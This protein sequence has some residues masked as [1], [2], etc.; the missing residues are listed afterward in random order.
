MKSGNMFIELDK[1]PINR[2]EAVDDSGIER[3]PLD[4]D[5][6]ERKVDLIRKLDF[7]SE[8]EKYTKRSRNGSDEIA[9]EKNK[10]P[11]GSTSWPW[12]S[13]IE[14]MQAAHQELSVIIDIINTV[15]ANDAVTVAGMTKPKPLTNEILSDL[16]V[17]TATKLQSIRHL[18]KYFKQGSK[19]FEKLVAKETRFYNALIRLQQNWKVK[20]HRLTISGHSNEGFTIDLMD[21]SSSESNTFPRPFST[22]I[23]RVDRDLNGKLVVQLPLR[24]FRS[25]YFRFFDSNSSRRLL[26]SLRS[27]MHSITNKFPLDGNNETVVE[28]VNECVKGSHSVL[29]NIHLSLFEEKVFDFVIH[30]ALASLSGVEIVTLYE[31]FLKLGVGKGASVNLSLML[32]DEADPKPIFDDPCEENIDSHT[33]LLEELDIDREHNTFKETITRFPNAACFQIHLTS[34]VHEYMSSRAKEGCRD[35]IGLI[36]DFCMT[37]AHSIFSQKVLSDLETLASG[38]PYL[39]LLTHPTWH[40][41]ISSWSL[42][43]KLPQSILNPLNAHKMRSEFNIKVTVTDDCVKVTGIGS[44]NVIDSFSG[45]S[46]F[47]KSVYSY[48]DRNLVD[49]KMSLL[50]KIACQLIQWLHEEALVLGLIASRDFLTLNFDIAEGSNMK[51]MA[52][53]DVKDGHC[54]ISWSMVVNE[55]DGKPL[56]EYSTTKSE[57]TIT[58]LGYLSLETLY[59]ILM[60]LVSFCNNPL[61]L[62]VSSHPNIFSS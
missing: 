42:F 39:R 32:S 62:V 12:Q 27:K 4:V 49:L 13:L 48:Y 3:F 19:S 22:S 23:I 44:P 33:N 41:R 47:S 5:P 56:T 24:S 14:S 34:T 40:S 10:K 25:L 6:E 35:E 37:G 26:H 52:H 59:S 29:R 50:L 60:D 2:V 15:E 58:F 45:N 57:G 30:E 53:V 17:S 46:S 28:N 55:N 61:N 1:L 16:S 36:S 21:I 54:S 38:I 11:P 31:N 9:K 7:S 8:V 18:G 20:R 51:L 43:V